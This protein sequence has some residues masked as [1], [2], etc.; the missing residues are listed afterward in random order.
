VNFPY[1]KGPKGSQIVA[2]CQCKACV[3]ANKASQSLYW[4]YWGIFPKTG[5]KEEK[6]WGKKY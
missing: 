2:I 5:N 4:K 1:F 3:S 6:K